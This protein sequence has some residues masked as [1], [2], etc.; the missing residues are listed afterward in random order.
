MSH[1]LEFLTVGSMEKAGKAAGVR[2]DPTHDLCL[3]QDLDNLHFGSKSWG[4]DTEKA[5]LQIHPP[6]PD[7]GRQ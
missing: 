3:L 1:W 4:L 5:H 6:T 7:E 2:M